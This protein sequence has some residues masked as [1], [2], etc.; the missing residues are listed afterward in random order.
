MSNMDVDM[1]S[2]TMDQ[3]MLKSLSFN[4]RLFYTIN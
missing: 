1:F 3:S 2:D 4:Y